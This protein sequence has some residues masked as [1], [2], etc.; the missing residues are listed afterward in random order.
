MRRQV[1]NFFLPLLAAGFLWLGAAS[2]GAAQLRFV[3]P[4][5][6][7]PQASPA[8]QIPPYQKG[9]AGRR[10]TGKPVAEL[11]PPRVAIPAPRRDPARIAELENLLQRGQKLESENRWGE[12]VAIYEEA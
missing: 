6:E 5:S 2:P 11:A 1:K 3:I 10:S 8:G 12:A 9:S 4:A 7:S